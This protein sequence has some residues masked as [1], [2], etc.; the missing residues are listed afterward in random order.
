MTS[1]L[2][3]VRGA[4]ALPCLA[5]LLGLLA[6]LPAAAHAKAHLWKFTEVFSSADG[7]VQFVEMFVFDP[8]GT[9]ETQFLGNQLASDANTYVFP[10][11][12]P[13][14]NTFNRWVLIGTQAF[15]DLPGA[16]Q[17][18]FIIPPNFFDPFDDTLVYRF[19]LD[20]FDLPPGALP[21][22]GISSLLLGGTIAPNSPTNFA[23]VAGS[24]VVGP[25]V[26]TVSLPLWVWAPL[27][28]LLALFVVRRLRAA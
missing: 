16:P 28:L 26:P 27:A 25:S 13:P 21:R 11:N 5:A 12:L 9:A 24:V 15:A 20:T 14:E 4:R 17:P 2:R 23:G 7:T 8:L 19:G 18:D 6:L 3:R 1:R 22:N 10:N